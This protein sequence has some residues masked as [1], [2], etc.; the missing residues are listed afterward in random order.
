MIVVEGMINI[1]FPSNIGSQSVFNDVW[2]GR[3]IVGVLRSLSERR[4]RQL[5]VVA[6]GVVL[7]LRYGDVVHDIEE[8]GAVVRDVEEEAAVARGVEL[9]PEI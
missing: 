9:Q 8:Y 4:D 5:S 1:G 6:T 2:D 7:D 3:T